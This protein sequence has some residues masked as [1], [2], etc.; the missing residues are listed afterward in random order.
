MFKPLLSPGL[1]FLPGPD[2]GRLGAGHTGVKV[3]PALPII[4]MLSMTST[5]GLVRN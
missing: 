4:F 2:D 1:F 3:A 5:I